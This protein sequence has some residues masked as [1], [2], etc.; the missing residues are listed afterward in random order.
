MPHKDPEQRKAYSSNYNQTNKETLLAKKKVRRT[1]QRALIWD[2]KRKPCTDCGIQY[3]P[4]VMDF[5]HVRGKKRFNLN[6]LVKIS[7]SWNTIQEEIAKCEVVCSNCHRARTHRRAYGT[8]PESLPVPSLYLPKPVKPK[9][10]KPVST[11]IPKKKGAW[12]SDRELEELLKNVPAQK[13]AEQ[14]GV[15]GSAL[16]RYCT[17][18]GIE[19]PPRGFW[20]SARRSG[21][22]PE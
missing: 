6:R 22:E 20:A 17:R 12:P 11:Y 21:L 15:S 9:P 19:T 7:A 13:I 8:E 14:V 18:R 5:D 10:S 2:H 4:W 3:D 1:E 16:K